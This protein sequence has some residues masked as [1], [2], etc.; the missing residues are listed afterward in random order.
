MTFI[1]NAAL[2]NEPWYLHLVNCT[3]L[4][5]LVDFTLF[6]LQ[7][8]FENIESITDKIIWDTEIET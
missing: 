3:N 7:I 4:S 8:S 2:H 6:L 1:V 5:L